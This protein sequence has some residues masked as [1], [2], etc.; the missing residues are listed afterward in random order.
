MEWCTRTGAARALSARAACQGTRAE[1][2][3]GLLR[4][5]AEG[6]GESL[7]SDISRIAHGG[8][9]HGAP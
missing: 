3:Y 5:V 6:C 9:G 2:R 7:G 8:A 4:L 1:A